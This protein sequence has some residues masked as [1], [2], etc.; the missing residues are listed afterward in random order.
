MKPRK[1]SPSDLVEWFS[2]LPPS[3]AKSRAIASQGELL[4]KEQRKSL[5]EY[6]VFLS[7][8]EGTGLSVHPQD[9][10]MHNPPMPDVECQ[11]LGGSHYFE[12]SEII[13]GKPVRGPSF[14]DE[15]TIVKPGDRRTPPKPFVYNPWG[16]LWTVLTKKLRKTYSPESRPRSLLLYYDRSPSC[17]DILAP[18]VREQSAEIERAL[19]EA[20][21]FDYLFIFDVKGGTLLNHFSAKPFLH[22]KA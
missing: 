2:M 16:Q 10:V 14:R 6:E 19:R 9:V 15:T 4:G 7:F 22:L 12:V 8:C 17:W 11:F 18:A 5:R 1:W 3:L 21:T 20:D 13:H